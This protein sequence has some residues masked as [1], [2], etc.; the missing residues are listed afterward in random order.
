M[1]FAKLGLAGCGTLPEWRTRWSAALRALPAG[2]Q[3][4]AVAYADWRADRSPSPDDVLAAAMEHGCRALLVDTF[5]K[6]GGG[7]FAHGPVEVVGVFVERTRAAGLL[8]VLAGSLEGQNLR[9]AIWLRPDYVAVR[10]AACR[11]SRDGQ[12]DA[13][14]TAELVALVAAEKVSDRLLGSPPRPQA[15]IR[16]EAIVDLRQG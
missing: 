6:R 13:A 7:L 15:N 1:H 3:T 4:V 14:R 8:A 9:Q 12:L 10:G 16:L 11:G 2:V 5:D